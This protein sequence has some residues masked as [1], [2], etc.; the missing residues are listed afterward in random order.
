MLLLLLGAS[1]A[2]QELDPGAGH[3]VFEVATVVVLVGEQDLPGP[4]GGQRGVVVEQ[5]GGTTWGSSALASVIANAMGRPCKVAV[6]CRR[7]PQK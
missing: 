5:V 6:R 7:S 1:R 4:G 2:A 3:G